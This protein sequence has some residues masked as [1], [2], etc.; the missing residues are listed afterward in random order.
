[1]N[2]T[3]TEARDMIARADVLA[4]SAPRFPLS[5]VGYAL[6]CAM[7]PMILLASH[8]AGPMPPAIAWAAI[9]PWGAAGIVMSVTLGLLSRPTPAGFGTRWAVMMVLWTL[10]W[11]FLVYRLG[12]GLT[13]TTTH[14]IA[15]SLVFLALAV[16]GP[17]W[18]LSAQYRRGMA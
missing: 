14:L 17:V 12:F 10:A 9:A 18:E 1:M 2:P 4:R 11:L 13:T 16:A 7:G 5:W 6:M 15:L 3:P 8:L